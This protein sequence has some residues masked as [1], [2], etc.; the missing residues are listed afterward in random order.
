MKEPPS[1]S[2]LTGRI[3]MPG[4]SAGPEAGWFNPGKPRMAEALASPLRPHKRTVGKKP[5]RRP[6]GPPPGN[7]PAD[8]PGSYLRLRVRLRE[9]VLSVEEAWTVKG[10][11]AATPFLYGPYVW[12]VRLGAKRLAIG[13][14]ADLGEVRVA[15]DPQHPKQASR[16][17]SISDAELPVRIPGDWTEG[18]LARAE[19]FLS[20]VKVRVAGRT[21]GDLP[22]HLQ[23][24]PELRL[25][26][27]LKGLLPPAPPKRTKR[28]PGKK[29]KSEKKSSAHKKRGR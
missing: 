24:R 23:W 13:D 29:T 18:E 6:P 5:P 8:Q 15:R 17:F 2:A 22:L 28:P 21:P 9:G 25:V 1:D 20:A 14:I 26:A 12:E 10:P 4:K 19:L 27:R 11:L 7:D 16:K 3:P